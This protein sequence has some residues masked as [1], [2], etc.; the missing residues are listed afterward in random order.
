MHF[1]GCVMDIKESIEKTRRGFEETFAAGDSYNWQSRDEE[2]LGKILGFINIRENMRA[3]DLVE[4]ET[5]I[6]VT[7]KVNNILFYKK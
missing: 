2:H 7:E 3:L 5:E 1:K 6:F 4:T